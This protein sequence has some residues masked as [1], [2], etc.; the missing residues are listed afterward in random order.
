MLEAIK[1][2]AF[3]SARNKYNE[4]KDLSPNLNENLSL[5]DSRI[6]GRF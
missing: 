3:C 1:V 2:D 5:M 4:F 6:K